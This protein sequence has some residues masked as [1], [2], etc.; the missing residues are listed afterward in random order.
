MPT[1]SFPLPKDLVEALDRQAA[2]VFLTRRAYV[3]TLL[4][5]VVRQ[6]EWENASAPFR[7]GNGA[8]QMPLPPSREVAARESYADLDPQTPARA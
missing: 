4:A 5:A 3:R 6:A 8:H 2:A 7:E 1:V